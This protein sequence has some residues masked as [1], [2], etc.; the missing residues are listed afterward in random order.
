MPA[1]MQCRC[2]PV[3]YDT[4]VIVESNASQRFG[5]VANAFEDQLRRDV[6][7]FLT[8]PVLGLCCLQSGTL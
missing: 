8:A 1:I 4:L 2:M 5:F 6:R 3:W 7:V